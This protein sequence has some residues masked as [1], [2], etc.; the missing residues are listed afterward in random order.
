M[1]KT[2]AFQTVAAMHENMVL[3]QSS[4]TNDSVWVYFIDLQNGSTNGLFSKT[5]KAK[6][7]YVQ[8]NPA[9]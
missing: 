8:L 5:R 1:L 3:L 4:L 6:K 9:S 2:A 7:L